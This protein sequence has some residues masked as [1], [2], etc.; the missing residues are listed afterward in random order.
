MYRIRN[1]RIPRKANDFTKDT[2]WTMSSLEIIINFLN[3][4]STTSVSIDLLPSLLRIANQV[5]YD[6]LIDCLIRSI[7]LLPGIVTSSDDMTNLLDTLDLLSLPLVTHL[8]K[9]QADK[10]DKAAKAISP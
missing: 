9:R 4:V 10:A 6:E 5:L 1:E 2:D 3:G 8:E 7:K